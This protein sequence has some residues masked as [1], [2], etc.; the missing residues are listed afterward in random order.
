MEW[1]KHSMGSYKA[2]F[3]QVQ[4]NFVTPLKLMWHPLLIMVLHVLV[5]GLL[6]DILNMLADVLD[7]FNELGFFFNFI[8]SRI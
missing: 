7:P 5:I 1:V 2:L 6:K 4:P 8:W 3:L